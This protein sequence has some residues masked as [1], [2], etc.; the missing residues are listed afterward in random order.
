MTPFQDFYLN[1]V[2]LS[3]LLPI[4]MGI[5][6]YKALTLPFKVLFYF[7]LAAVPFEII[8]RILTRVYT[9]NMPGQHLYTA[10]EFLTFSLVFYMCTFRRRLKLLIVINALIFLFLAVRDATHNIWA[11]NELSH[12]YAAASMMLYS[13]GYLYYLFTIDD[14]RYM[15]EYPMF[16]ICISM[17]IY[18]ALN[19]LY[20]LGES[21][22]ILKNSQIAWGFHLT[23]G[24]LN[25]IANCLYAQS[26]RCFGKQKVTT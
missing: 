20:F 25:I 23:H 11:L 13:L 7:S 21:I 15:K 8:S 10:L 18:F 19:V 26:F 2:Q 24:T 14:T 22:L 16:W 3:A 12:G 17:L 1:L 6:Y 5:R 4:A 9:N